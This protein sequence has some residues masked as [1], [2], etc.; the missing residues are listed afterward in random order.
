M[1]QVDYMIGSDG[2]EGTVKHQLIILQGQTEI[3]TQNMRRGKRHLYQHHDDTTEKVPI[4]E[5]SD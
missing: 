1:L 3:Q 4:S 5:F 2:I